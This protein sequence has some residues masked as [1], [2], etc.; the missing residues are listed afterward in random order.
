MEQTSELCNLSIKYSVFPKDGKIAKLK[1]LYKKGSTTLPKNYRPISLL[2]LI[3]KIIEKVIHDQ[4]QA[5]LDE[6]IILYRFQSRFRKHFSTDSCL[7]YLNN[8][9]ATGFKS[10]LHTGMILIDLQKAFNTI[11]HKILKNKMEFLGFSQNV[12]LSFKSYLSQRKFKVNLNKSFSEPGQPLCGAP[13]GSI[14]GP[15]LFLLY[16]N[17]MLM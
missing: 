9:I 11:N 10:G 6:N 1:H 4:T 3:S 7:S 5:F 16:I 14:L 17:D 12:I 15:L 2:P 8:K 13:Q